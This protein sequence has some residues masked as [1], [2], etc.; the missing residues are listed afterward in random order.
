MVFVNLL[1]VAHPGRR[2]VRSLMAAHRTTIRAAVYVLLVAIPT[3]VWTVTLETR[4]QLFDRALTRAEAERQH[5]EL[6]LPVALALER[7][8]ELA[9]RRAALEDEVR[10]R[11]TIDGTPLEAV[12]KATPAD[13]W[14]LEFVQKGSDATLRGVA[15]TF[16]HVSDFAAAL[17]ES[18][19]VEPPIEILQ[20][21][22]ARDPTRGA[23]VSFSLKATV[24]R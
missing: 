3:G 23:M 17:E 11:P 21:D 4:S 5:V 2:R 12:A 15:P 7:S 19:H 13:V 1:D 9:R 20:T 18:P 24:I 22:I 16:T 10:R 8:E 14:L 6:L